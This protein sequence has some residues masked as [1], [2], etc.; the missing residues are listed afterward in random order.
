MNQLW[1][2]EDISMADFVILK[3]FSYV[4]PFSM[5]GYV[6]KYKYLWD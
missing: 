2:I 1:N 3:N 4:F 5:V 6:V